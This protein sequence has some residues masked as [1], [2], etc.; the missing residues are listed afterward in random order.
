MTTTTTTTIVK[1][2]A[3]DQV[4]LEIQD[5]VDPQALEQAKAIVKEL[6]TPVDVAGGGGA[7]DALKLL[8]VATRLGDVSSDNASLQENGD[9]KDNSYK[10][11]II[12]K[13]A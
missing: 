5:P 3:P 1:P 9:K 10:Q 8:A 6:R 2:L 13:E 4:S 12:T 11:Y 7:V